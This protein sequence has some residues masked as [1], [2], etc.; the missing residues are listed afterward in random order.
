MQQHRTTTNL[1]AWYNK[2][3][4]CLRRAVVSD[5][6]LIMETHHQLQAWLRSADVTAAEFARRCEYDPSNMSKLLK[7]TLRPTLDM[8]FRIER[9]TDGKVPAS[10]WVEAA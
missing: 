8:A 6:T 10:S 2:P 4:S 9:A 1:G 3:L 7:G 5:T